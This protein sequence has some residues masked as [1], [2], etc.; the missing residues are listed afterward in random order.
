MKNNMLVRCLLCLLLAVSTIS[1][2]HAQLRIEIIGGGANQFPIALVPL[3][4]EEA[5][6]QKITDIVAADLNRSGLFKMIDGGGLPVI[7]SEPAEVIFPIFKARSADYLAIGSVSP[8]ANG[9]WD[10][11]FRLLDVDKRT[12]LTGF[13]YQVAPQQLRETAHR[14]ADAIYEKVTGDVGVF[15]TRITYVVKSGTRFEL[16]VADADGYGAKTVLASNEPILSPAWSP[17]GTR[18]AYV[19][20][21]RKKPIVYLQSLLTGQRSIVA[22]FKGSNSAPAWSP[23]GKRLAV[24]LTK[25]GS[26]QIYLVDPDGGNAVRLTSST[27]IDTEPNFAPDGQSILFTSDRG[28]SPQI[29]RVPVSGG[30]PVRVT[31]DGS[32]NVSPRHAPDGKSFVFVQRNG[33]RFNVALQDFASK[34][35]QL[36]TEN[37]ND[38]SPTFAPNGRIIL[39]ATE[40]RG[41]GILAA[42]SSDGRVRQRL[43]VEA[44]D[45]R[46]PAWGPVSRAP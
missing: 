40:V 35:A 24:V 36:L 44:G 11:R 17:D 34:Q 6:P 32:Y 3:K 16:Q 29:Y 21:E 33:G 20:F 39:Y 31:F 27:A 41:R 42:V 28:G 8:L 10:V 30:T 45:V 2:A 1:A 4:G 14:M 13:A 9:H 19:S 46:E 37:S 5:L 12:Q 43:T 15:S 22:N 25:D 38:E 26:S 18:I 7:P 23:D